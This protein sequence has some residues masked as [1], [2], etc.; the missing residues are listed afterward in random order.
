MIGETNVKKT[1]ITIEL[2]VVEAIE[3]CP[4]APE[5]TQIRLTNQI[6]FPIADVCLSIDKE[7]RLLVIET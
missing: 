2:D 3:V 5:F 6:S 4:T 7:K 1:H